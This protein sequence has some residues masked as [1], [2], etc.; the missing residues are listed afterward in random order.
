MNGE[1]RGIFIEGEEVRGVEPDGWGSLAKLKVD[2]DTG[3][4][5]LAE[6]QPT[7]QDVLFAAHY[8]SYLEDQFKDINKKDENSKTG[9]EEG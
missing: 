9:I 2:R 4:I 1:L 7:N 3:G 8:I 5:E 6:R